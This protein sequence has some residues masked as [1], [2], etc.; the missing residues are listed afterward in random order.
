MK[1][2]AKTANTLHNRF[3]TVMDEYWDQFRVGGRRFGQQPTEDGYFE[4]LREALHAGGLTSNDALTVAD[5]GIRQV[6]HFG[7]FAGKGGKH[8]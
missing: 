3:H 7:Y 1:G 4:A 2:S 6:K 8:S 5:A